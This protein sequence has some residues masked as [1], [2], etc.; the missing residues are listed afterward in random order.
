[1]GTSYPLPQAFPNSFLAINFKCFSAH[2]DVKQEIPNYT[3]YTPPPP[4]PH[5]SQSIFV[6]QQNI[7]IFPVKNVQ[8]IFRIIKLENPWSNSNG[9]ILRIAALTGNLTADERQRCQK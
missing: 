4:P 5:P 1:M 8:M 3:I 6:K 2:L 7:Q 9:V